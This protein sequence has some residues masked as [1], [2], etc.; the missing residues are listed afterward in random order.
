MQTI[1]LDPNQVPTH[2]RGDYSGRS[3]KARIG[4]TMTIPSTAGLWE[5]GSRD[6][7]RFI[8]ITD[9]A[10]VDAVKHQLAPWDGSRRDIPVTLRPGFA[11]VE[12]SYFCGKDMGLT[13]YVH[14][15]DA[16]PMLPAPDGQLTDTEQKVIN[17]TCSYKSSYGGRDRYEMA[18]DDY[19]PCWA[20]PDP[21]K[22]PFPTR[23][24][25]E[26]AKAALASR[27]Y[28]NKAGAITPKG[29]NARTR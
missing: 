9:G 26:A 11:V 3:F 6:T 28:L 16:A 1:H 5:G 12:H 27:G 18:R 29:R 7:F 20:K 17:A 19:A 25:W 8:R 13:F 14:P 10:A 23:E 2:M 24:E 4:E 21:A 15:S 22:A